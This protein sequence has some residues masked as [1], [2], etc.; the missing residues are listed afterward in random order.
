M[1]FC[2]FIC[3]Y[4]FFAVK[5][6]N[7]RYQFTTGQHRQKLVIWVKFFPVHPNLPN[8]D[9]DAGIGSS[10][11]TAKKPRITRHQQKTLT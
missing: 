10:L 7:N 1:P 11:P 2:I 8:S 9:L 5:M 6:N 3:Q 4:T